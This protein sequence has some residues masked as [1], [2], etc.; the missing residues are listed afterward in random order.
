MRKSVIGAIPCVI[1]ALNSIKE[2]ENGVPGGTV[3]GGV[4]PKLDGGAFI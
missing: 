1:Y 3:I 2:I 4:V